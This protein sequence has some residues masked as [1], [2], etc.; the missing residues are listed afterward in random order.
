[1]LF[2]GPVVGTL[3]F[4]DCRVVGCI[5]T[6][7]V[8]QLVLARVGFARVGFARVVLAR[9]GFVR[10]VLA[11]VG[12]V[13]VAFDRVFGA[14]VVNQRG[15]VHS[16]AWVVGISLQVGIS[17]VR[18]L[19]A[20]RRRALDDGAV[21]ALAAVL[22]RLKFFA[23]RSLVGSRKRCACKRVDALARHRTRP[24]AIAPLL[25]PVARVERV[26]GL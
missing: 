5:G 26:D 17:L 1:M 12:F 13:R 15:Q 18:L 20:L 14:G 4:A 16:I 19:V 10:V 23:A 24:I 2:E 7:V 6:S 8:S 21:L 11:R 22:D 25:G 9:V 3:L